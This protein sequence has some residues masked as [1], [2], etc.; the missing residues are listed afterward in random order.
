MTCMVSTDVIRTAAKWCGSSRDVSLVQSAAMRL[1]LSV[2]GA[3]LTSMEW[4]DRRM[5]T[6]RDDQAALDRMK[7]AYPIAGL[8]GLGLMFGLRDWVQPAQPLWWV[9]FVTVVAIGASLGWTA[10]SILLGKRAA[11]TT[12]KGLLTSV[13]VLAIAAG[14]IVS[15][16]LGHLGNPETIMWFFG[17]CPVSMAIAFYLRRAMVKFP[18][19]GQDRT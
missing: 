4:K 19:D 13:I 18:S 17:L 15:H 5:A 8:L 9:A 11:K 16:A 3:L 6:D 7:T 1:P 14:G 10:A 2:D 12:P